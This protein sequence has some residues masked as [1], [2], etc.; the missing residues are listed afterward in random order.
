MAV[1]NINKMFK[2]IG[3]VP[4]LVGVPTAIV[5]YKRRQDALNDPVLNRA[6]LHL[7]ND[8]RIIDFCGEDITPGWI[9]T[10]KQNA[11]ENWIMYDLNIKGY[12]GKLKTTVIGDFLEHRELKTLEQERQKWVEEKLKLQKLK[13]E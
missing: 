2:F 12:S 8:Q 10:K 7:R 11:N 13:E 6:L 9:I 4:V 3:A 5:G 1:I